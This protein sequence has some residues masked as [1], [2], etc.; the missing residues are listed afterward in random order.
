VTDGP[1][2]FGVLLPHFGPHANRNRIVE[3]SAEIERL[4]FDSI[5]VRDHIVFRP[6]GHEGGDSTFWEPTL[7]L[8]AI[9]AVTS[10]VTLATGA[11]IPY[12]HPLHTALLYGTLDHL[13]G[14]DRLILGFGLGSFDHEF[15]AVG[16]GSWDRRKVLPE[17]VE[18][19]RKVWREDGVSHQGEFYSFSDVAISPKPLSGAVPVWYSGSS[20]AS[21]RRA[22]EFCDGWVPGRMPRRDFRKRVER[23]TRL[24]EEA[25]RPV[26]ATGTIPYV[27]PGRTMEQ[28]T[29][30]LHLDALIE[31]TAR[32]YPPGE[33]GVFETLEDL[34][35][36]LVAGPPDVL[37]E[38]VVKHV[39]SGV[40][41]F[42]F[43]MRLRFDRYEEM[44]DLVARDVL[45]EVRRVCAV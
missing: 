13:T 33:S 36:A 43:D 5:W 23:M 30:G 27:S 12:R 42:V 34:D 40:Q 31:E 44:I 25:G 41:H 35:G 24:A 21:V 28:A 18:I 19:M 20:P 38:E 7:A 10:R 6:H 9:A 16:M 3:R 14:G 39:E 8:A 2:R 29:A 22:V 45:P 4:G 32:R 26:P 11:L 37:V 17:Q 1:P 15:E